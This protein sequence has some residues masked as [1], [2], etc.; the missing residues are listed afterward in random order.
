MALLAT[1]TDSFGGT[2]LD[3]SK[4]T[5]TSYSGGTAVVSSGYLACSPVAN[6][7]NT[8]GNVTSANSYDLT[9]SYGLVKVSQVV[10]QNGATYFYVQKDTNNKLLFRVYQG[11]LSARSID[12]GFEYEQATT[13][14][15]STTHAWLKIRESGGITYFD[16]SSDGK[17]W[18]NFV[19]FSNLSAVT[20]M[21]VLLEGYD[22]SADTAPGSAKF[23][24][25]NISPLGIFPTRTL[26]G[27]GS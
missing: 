2:S 6:T 11:N 17:T 25:F 24:N 5:N 8:S 18:A 22:W 1:L 10:A 4:W 14:Y 21:K 12:A 9:G 26:L 15:N 7:G 20:S 13:T 16:T 27:V 19:S 23:V 3:T